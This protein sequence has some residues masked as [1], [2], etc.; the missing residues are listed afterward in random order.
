MKRT[1]FLAVLM[2]LSG[3]A[4]L[5]D[6]SKEHPVVTGIGAALLV[7]GI[8]AAASSDGGSKKGPDPI[9]V[10]PGVPCYQQPN[11]SCR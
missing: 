2:A 9:A 1:I 3:C 7:G 5:Q 11:G 6:F 8:A 10:H 4:S